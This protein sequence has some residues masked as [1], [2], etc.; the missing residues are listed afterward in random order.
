[1]F[2]YFTVTLK[3]CSR[4]YYPS[5]DLCP[6]P[7][8][9]P[10]FF[11]QCLCII[12]ETSYNPPPFYRQKFIYFLMD[13][14][15]LRQIIKFSSLGII[16]VLLS[17][18][19]SKVIDLMKSKFSTCIVSNETDF[20]CVFYF[21]RCI[22]SLHEFSLFF[23]ISKLIGGFCTSMKIFSI[24]LFVMGQIND[25]RKTYCRNLLKH[26]VVIL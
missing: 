1:M 5:V 3:V 4:I 20:T 11:H 6:F 8:V 19:S 7:M 15:P 25:L 17:N 10:Q 13:M 2:P 12:N 16:Y 21:L 24:L 9:F 22:S 18:L 26:E 14:F 23:C